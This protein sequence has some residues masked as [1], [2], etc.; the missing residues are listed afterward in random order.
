MFDSLLQAWDGEEVLV[1]FDAPSGAWMFACI[2]STRLGPA[3]GGTRMKVYASPAAALEDGLRL[4]SAMTRKLAVSGLPYG[5][6]KAVLAVPA[7]PVGEPRRTLLERYAAFVDSLGGTYH[8]APDVNTND[9]DMDV[10]ALHTRWVFGKSPANGGAG[11]TAP[12]TAVGVLHG[13]RACAEHVFGS[14]DLARRTVVVQGAGDIGGRLAALLA[15]AGARVLLADVDERRVEELAARI[16]ATVVPAADALAT[17]C[18]VLA[19]CAL[20]GVLSA[21]TIPALR[22]RVVCGAANNQLATDADGDRFADRGI[23]YA[24]DYVVNAGGVLHG[25]GLE[26]L[27]WA[28]P[29]LDRRLAAIADTLHEIIAIAETGGIST[30]RAAERLARARLAAGPGSLPAHGT[31]AG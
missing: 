13:M 29:E 31:A 1:R 19:P 3:A 14:P 24:P 27:G 18:D 7:I 9:A 15:Q 20:G 30:E 16:G 6:G 5:G 2:H 12:A 21:E 8:T 4:S 25:L 28:Q 10:V 22:C 17:G 11:N 26:E 23:L